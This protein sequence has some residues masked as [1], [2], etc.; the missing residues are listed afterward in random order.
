MFTGSHVTLTLRGIT[1]YNNSYINVNDIGGNTAGEALLCHIENTDCCGTQGG[2]PLSE[3]YYPNGSA[4]NSIADNDSNHEINGSNNYFSA[5]RSQSILRL[6]RDGAPTERGCFC[7]VI[8]ES[9]DQGSDQT[10]CVNL[11]K[12]VVTYNYDNLH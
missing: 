4:L 10:L 9:D 5:T 11:G 7:C 3:W 2:R 12:K 8:P 1:I 6:F